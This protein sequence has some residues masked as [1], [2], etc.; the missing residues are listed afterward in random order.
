M[1][2]GHL[3]LLGLIALVP[4]LGVGIGQF[5]VQLM[6]QTLRGVPAPVSVQAPVEKAHAPDL[7]AWLS[8][9]EIVFGAGAPNDPCT[10][11][12]DGPMHPQVWDKLVDIGIEKWQSACL[13]ATARK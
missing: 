11:R 1:K 10:A 6:L 8:Q 2:N 7:L 5:Y 12:F 13:E 3:F 4:V 9:D